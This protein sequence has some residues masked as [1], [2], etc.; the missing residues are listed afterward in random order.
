MLNQIN[1]WAEH[2][3]M[4]LDLILMLRILTLKLRQTYTFITLFALMNLFYDGIEL[5]LGDKSPEFQRVWFF[6]KFIFA[7]VYPLAAWDVFEEAK[8]LLDQVRKIAM[9][10]MITSLLFISLWGLLIA[11]FTGAEGENQSQYMMRLALIIWTGSVAA[12]LSFFW[13]MRRGIKMQPFELPKNTII[14]RWYFQLLLIVEAISC[15]LYMAFEFVSS[16]SVKVAENLADVVYAALEVC[17]IALT[18]WCVYKLRRV[19]SEVPNTSIN[20]KG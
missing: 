13:V 16:D 3:G 14:W 17:V 12:V 10:R 7:V 19:S 20:V 11:A 18:C 1:E 9:S 4:V 6:S 15:L 2:V 8:A 5:R